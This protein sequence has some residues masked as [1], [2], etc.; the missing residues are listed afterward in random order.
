VFWA[1]REGGGGQVKPRTYI[2]KPRTT[3]SGPWTVPALLAAYGWPTGLPNPGA[4]IGILEMGGG[5]VASDMQAFFE[6]LSMP[7]PTIT[8]VSVDGTTNTPTPGTDSADF[9]VALDIQVAAVAYYVATGV[10]PN[11]RVYWTQTQATA[12]QQAANDG[13]AVMSISWGDSESGWSNS[14]MQATEA[15]AAA[16]VAAGMTVFAAA[17][18]NDADDDDNN[19][20]PSVDCP[21]SCPSVVGCGG[22]TKP[23]S[24]TEIVW[25]NSPPGQPNGEGTGGGYSAV[26]PVQAW[27]VGVPAAPAG[28]GR[29][30]P[31]VAAN[32]DPNTG[33]T[34]YAHGA[35]TVI[36]GT[37]AVAPLYAGLFAALGKQQGVLAKIWQNGG[38]FSDITQGTNGYYSAAVGPDPC[39]G[40]GAPV[41]SKIA[42][43]FAATSTPA[44]TPTPIPTP[45][46]SGPPTLAEVQ[47]ALSGALSQGFPLVPRKVAVQEAL[48]AVAALFPTS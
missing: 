6:S 33:Y 21:A 9:E 40:L 47:A 34:I 7:V 12:I 44:P 37:S 30:V 23:Q 4:T 3:A 15:A 14:D 41:A 46:P 39:T 22:T 31:D 38:A 25:D 26:F 18:D 35:S 2:K 5:W 10:M 28:L 43:L 19:G 1:V 45:T 13:C 11:I 29:M 36:G 8:D 42:A 24:G 16:A 17:G 20:Q 27:Q 32:A 48:A